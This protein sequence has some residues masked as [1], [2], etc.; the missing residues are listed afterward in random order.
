MK[1]KIDTIGNGF[2]TAKDINENLKEYYG[3][4]VAYRPINGCN[5]KWL[6][7]GTKNSQI[8]IIAEETVENRYLTGRG[9][10]KVGTHLVYPKNSRKDSMKMVQKKRYYKGFKDKECKAKEV[11]CI[12]SKISTC[13]KGYGLRPI[14]ILG[15]NT[16]F[17]LNSDG[18]YDIIKE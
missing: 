11:D 15:E 17:K 4:Y 12:I 16:K 2:I 9:L 6:I 14:V 1:D 18:V 3:K 8:Y 7:F 5:V 13:T 10:E